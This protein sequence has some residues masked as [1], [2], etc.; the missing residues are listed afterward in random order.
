MSE[1]QQKDFEKIELTAAMTE[2]S[3]LNPEEG[4]GAMMAQVDRAAL[5][6]LKVLREGN[7]DKL[8]SD[9]TFLA[10]IKFVMQIM[11][12]CKDFRDGQFTRLVRQHAED[13]M[14]G[15]EALPK[16]SKEIKEEKKRKAEEAKRL[17]EQEESEARARKIASGGDGSPI[18]EEEIEIDE[19]PEFNYELAEKLCIQSVVR[20][21]DS[22]LDVLRSTHLYGRHSTEDIGIPAHFLYS[23]EFS[24]LIED[25][26][27]ALVIDSREVLTRRV[28][29]DIDPEADEEAIRVILRDKSKPLLEV[30]HSGFSGW[31]SS[32]TEA[33]KRAGESDKPKKAA[34]K[35]KKGGLFAKLLG[36]GKKEEAPKKKK[37]VERETWED[38][39]D[40]FKE[41]QNKG[42]V[43]FP[44]TFNFSI[45]AYLMNLRDNL[46]KGEG[47]RIIQIAE[48][49]QGG[50]SAKGAV[51]RAL[52]QSFKQNDQNF[53]EMLILNLLYTKNSIGLDEVQ[54]AC[55]GQKLDAGRLPL[56][57][58]ELGR[59]PVAY[60]EQIIKLLKEPAEPRVLKNCLEFF[61]ESILVLH[62]IKFDKE[63]KN[64]VTHFEAE[65]ENLAKP[66]QGVVDGVLGLIDRVLFARQQARETGEDTTMQTKDTINHTIGKFMTA[67][68]NMYEKMKK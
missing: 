30:V 35:E 42:E 17:A 56:S 16:R 20:H 55:M 61:F 29:N 28:Y 67:Y 38:V 19:E 50:S 63:F 25:A 43:F 24:V 39:L 44:K 26:V 1:E 59:R 64:A 10:Q 68:E 32:Q 23:I 53:F 7:P 4:K 15:L 62:L 6:V 14:T 31:G 21:F 48:Q 3:S 60:A 36:K 46:F 22:K 33:A 37:K 27:R 47:D 40:I 34:T 52:E 9:A 65:K 57:V 5:R 11:E 2:L 13:I 18:H 49:A 58:P 54:S 41:A 66:L 45:L 8:Q 12:Q 51:A